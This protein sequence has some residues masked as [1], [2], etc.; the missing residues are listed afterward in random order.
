MI[1]VLA[2]LAA[3][4]LA[5]TAC[6]TLTSL[7]RTRIPPLGDQLGAFDQAVVDQTTNRLFLAESKQTQ[8]LVFDVRTAGPKYITSIQVGKGPKG[9][10][11]APDLRKLYVGLDG[12]E[13]AVID[14]DPRSARYSTVLRNVATGNRKTSDLLGYDATD[15]RLFVGSGD[16]SS[17]TA[18]DAV[19]D[20]AS[21]HLSLGKS[22]EQPVYDA[23]SG[24]LYVTAGAT[25]N[26]VYKIDPKTL[27]VLEKW[28]LDVKCDPLGMGLNP[29]T[30]DA[31]LGC[32][33]PNA[34]SAVLFNVHTGK[35][36][37][38]FVEIS[39]GDQVVYLPTVNRYLYAGTAA[40]HTA[41][42]ILGG[43][44]VRFQNVIQTL[45]NTKAVA[46]DEA[47]RTVY[48]PSSKPGNDGVMYF[49]LPEP[50]PEGD[51][52]WT[53]VF[54]LVPLVLLGVVVWFFGRR[55][56]RERE[57]AGRPMFS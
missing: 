21:G 47:T 2:A 41:I 51:S 54:Y 40:T 24:A 34:S 16:D 57:L 42:G 52:P 14:L 32:S 33:D 8:V 10:A 29:K 7:Q 31:L 56:A 25:Q 11:I 19:T 6:G 48:L 30:G 13:V 4:L 26:A 43:H 15:H 36:V 23:V 12:G 9:L 1:K 39:S 20:L 3:G 50:Q 45:S 28:T 49:A 44:P 22:V 37:H 35:V 46:Y 38:S 5:V 27:K 18:I 55:R 17:L 53:P